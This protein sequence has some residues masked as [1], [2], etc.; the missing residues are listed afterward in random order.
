M[1]QVVFWV[2][3][4]I[5]AVLVAKWAAQEARRVNAELD[6]VKA[7]GGAEPKDAPRSRL[8]RDPVTGHFRP[9]GRA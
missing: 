3:G 4:A 1:P 7:A 9:E 6:A 2:L 8:V 5:G